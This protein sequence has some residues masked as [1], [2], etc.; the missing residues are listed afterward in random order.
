MSEADAL[1]APW[2]AAW[3]DAL[4][5]W[6]RVVKLKEP[7]W[8]L[9]PDEE[10]KEGLTGSFAMIRL[11]DHAVV[12]SLRQVSAK[13]LAPY[14]TEILAHEIGH[15]MLAPGDLG[16]HARC[17]VKMRGGLQDLAKKAG[18][19]ANLYTDLLINDRLQRVSEL[20]MAEI[21]RALMSRDGGVL[22][23]FYMRI[24]ENLWGLP[25]GELGGHPA[26]EGADPAFELDAQLGARLVRHYSKDWLSGAGGF[27]ALCYPYL[28]VDEEQRKQFVMLLDAESGL[29]EGSEMPGGL[30]ELDDDELNGPTHPRANPDVNGLP[31]GLLDDG[32]GKAPDEAGIKKPMARPRPPA[33]F[34]E[35]MRSLGV[36]L[37]DEEIICQYYRE[38]ALPHLVPFPER[39]KARAVDPL[40]ESLDTWDMGAPMEEIDWFESVLVSPVIVPGV[41]TVRRVYGTTEGSDPEKEP[42]DLYLGVDCSGSMTNPAHGLSYPV[43]AGAV[44][45]LSALRAGASVM[46]VLSGE[47]GKY[48]STDGFVR[49]EGEVLRTL[50]A[51][52]GTGYTFGIPRLVETFTEKPRPRPA[53]ILIVTDSDIYHMLDGKDGVVGTQ[54]GWQVAKLARERAGGGGTMVLHGNLSH[55]EAKRQQLVGDGWDVHNLSSQE[56]LV[57]FARAFAA[58][59]YKQESK[60]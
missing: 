7:R 54:T 34:R 45:A 4:A 30:A 50:T 43:V 20:R 22:W 12:V 1:L 48:T 52:L 26:P 44:L 55:Y 28:K 42:L 19:I 40:P 5:L 59:V 49:R 14:A 37:S 39:I 6:S 51:Y 31:E 29:G 8:C 3:P 56:D 57:A 47:P 58:R 53:H 27:A 38:L 23:A 17:L 16:D 24:Y 13:R 18:F 33:D 2:R 36:K 21:Y 32:D 15:H 41:T 60:S 9:L 35:L 46:V 10:R 11:D 25:P